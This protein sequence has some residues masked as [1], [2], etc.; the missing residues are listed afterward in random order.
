MMKKPKFIYFHYRSP[1]CVWP[2]IVD[3]VVYVSAAIHGV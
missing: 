2:Y 1:F 3:I